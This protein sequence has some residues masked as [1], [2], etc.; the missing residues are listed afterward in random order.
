MPMPAD[1]ARERGEILHGAL[2]ELPFEL[3][4]PLLRGVRRHA[5]SLVPGSLYTADGACAVGLMLDELRG[6]RRRPRF[7]K[8]KPT[9]RQEAPEIVRAY[10]RMAHV[11]YVFDSTC[12]RLGNR[13]RVPPGDVA[14]TVGLWMASEVH[15]EINLRHMEEGGSPPPAT[16]KAVLDEALFADTVARL[17]ELRP[18]LSE[19]QAIRAVESLIRARRPEDLFVPPEW[20]S[21]VELQRERLRSAAPA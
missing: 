6:G 19:E 14:P 5:D 10:P 21:E 8:P 7:R 3:L 9:I 1:I 17:R 12:K 2:R 13:L 11:E 4:A 16:A 20:Q 18:W 15:A